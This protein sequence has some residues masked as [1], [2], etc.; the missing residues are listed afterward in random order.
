MKHL[1]LLALL[2]ACGDDKG[3]SLDANIDMAT[4]PPTKFVY[5]NFEGVTLTQGESSPSA[6][7]WP[8]QTRTFGPFLETHPQ[9]S[10][11]IEGI[12][13]K[14]RELL[15]PYDIGVESE[16][17]AEK[18]M[19]IVFTGLAEN[20]GSIAGNAG[21]GG[22]QCGLSANS[23]IVA[24]QYEL[25]DDAT[26]SV[27]D[28]ANMHMFL[29][30]AEIGLAHGVVTVTEPGNCMC[31]NAVDCFNFDYY[32]NRCTIQGT[33]PIDTS[34]SQCPYTGTTIDISAEFLMKLK[35]HP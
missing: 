3:S 1:L 18:Y 2:A 28:V 19:M 35:A 22:I 10:A 13:E 5:L 11:I 16:R 31:W 24:T 21:D 20:N 27:E 9:R 6:N 33:V 15:A 14:T 4:N 30:V 32:A 17:P 8:G 23:S 26:R 25:S 7:T 34:V 29:T 12:V